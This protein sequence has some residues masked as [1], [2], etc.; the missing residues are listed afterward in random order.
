MNIHTGKYLIKHG[1][2]RSDVRCLER[3][4]LSR[5][6]QYKKSLVTN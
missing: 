2:Y 5:K 1:R 4:F 6:R 3:Y